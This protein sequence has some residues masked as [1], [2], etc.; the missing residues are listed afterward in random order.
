MCRFYHFEG[1]LWGQKWQKTPHTGI[2]LMSWSSV[3]FSFVQ[4]FWQAVIEAFG[5]QP[6]ACR[7]QIALNIST[8]FC[9]N[10]KS[11]HNTNAIKAAAMEVCGED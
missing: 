4:D 8:A 11:D 5:V 10:L 2:Y 6:A 7:R 1:F 9:P 3:S